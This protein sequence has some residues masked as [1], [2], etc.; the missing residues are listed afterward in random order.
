MIDF[1]TV[2]LDVRSK[3]E[4]G[5]LDE[6]IETKQIKEIC[7]VYENRGEGEDWE[8][9]VPFTIIKVESHQ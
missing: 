8:S 6:D 5:T 3:Y 2:R 7:V 4:G 9:S 1:V